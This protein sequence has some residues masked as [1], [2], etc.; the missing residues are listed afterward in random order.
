ML[1]MPGA[2]LLLLAAFAG[3]PAAAQTLAPPEQ[4][5]KQIY[6]DGAERAV[7]FV[8]RDDTKLPAS[9]MPCA[10]CH[11]RD[12]AGRAEGGIVPPD[13]TWGRLTKPYT[14]RHANGRTHPPYDEAS[15]L[16]A[17]TQGR[18]P[19]G[20]ALDPTM[21]RYRLEPQ[22]AQDLIAYLKKLEREQDRG[23]AEDTILVGTVVPADGRA[24]AAGQ[25]V[26]RV[27]QAYFDD[28]N[29]T[30]G[31]FQRRIVLKVEAYRGNET[32]AAAAMRLIDAGVFALVAPFAV[33]AQAEL[34]AL[35][36]KHETPVLGPF[37]LLPRGSNSA[38]R[39]MF[40]LTTALEDQ[41]RA[42]L[43]YA[44]TRLNLD[45]PRIAVVIPPG[46]GF[47]GVAQAITQE[48]RNQGW[49]R[50]STHEAAERGEVL[51][52]LVATLRADGV[53]AVFYMGGAPGLDAFVTA[54]ALQGWSPKLFAPGASLG[55]NLSVG[56]GMLGKP[57][58]ASFPT[59]QSDR[60]EAGVME[61]RR[62]HVHDG[63][64]ARLSIAE[65]SAYAAARVFVEGLRRTGRALTRSK[66]VTAL[67][68]LSQFET[69]L[70]PSISFGASRRFA[71]T[72][73]HILAI[74]AHGRS[75][76]SSEAWIAPE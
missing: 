45:D 74:D 59:M 15:L 50:I 38:Q 7:A 68:G 9:R 51:A 21:P 43:T 26:L 2:A 55:P 5:G 60:K 34:Q 23:I 42:L 73:S 17:I 75:V 39:H 70:L 49:G 18:D 57:I 65:I 53:D 71:A 13:I 10:G 54:V 41:A 40:F 64:A 8:G 66:L 48:G 37:V 36:E 1:R 4:R 67:E 16:T 52:P 44:R 20:N 19:A 56:L 12:G 28:V 35:A 14:Q 46:P 61:L 30:G 32:P 76:A 62:L 47:S 58:F 25:D 29:R 24:A 27:L 31:I 33:G 6:L 3:I 72:G 69:G 11:G 22:Q 63:G